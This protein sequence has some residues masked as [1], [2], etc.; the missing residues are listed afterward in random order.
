MIARL[1]SRAQEEKGFTLIE[2][3]VVVLIIGILAAIAIPAFLGQKKG[4]QDAN[5]KSLLRNGAIA[6]ESFYSENQDFET[7]TATAGN[8][9]ADLLLV[10][11]NIAWNDPTTMTSPAVPLAKSNQV[12]I[13]AVDST[14][15][16]LPADQY[17]LITQS[18]SGGFFAYF[19]DKNAKTIKCKGATSFLTTLPA[20]GSTACPTGYTGTW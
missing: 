13:A 11:P 18:A 8:I 19:R 6:M 9:A 2:L 4:A 14:G 12:M 5:A 20:T 10:E 1:R 17:G 16:S 3:L 7:N 15:G